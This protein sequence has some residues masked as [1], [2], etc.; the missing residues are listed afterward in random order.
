MRYRD[1]G[2][3]GLRVSELVVGGGWVGG[4]LIHQDD[5]TKLAA[6]RRAVQAGINWIDTAPSYGAGKSEEALGR[7]LPEVGGTQPHLSTKFRIDPERADDILGQIEASLHESLTR[8]RRDSV[9]LLQLHNPLR[10]ESGAGALAE[11]RVLG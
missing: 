10:P 8:L 2:R 6:L 4:L 1:F 11:E 5:D 3:T 9:E 7:L